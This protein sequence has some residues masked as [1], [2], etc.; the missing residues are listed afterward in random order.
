MTRICILMMVL[1]LAGCA[2]TFKYDNVSYPSR[3]LALAAARTDTDRKVAGVQVADEKVGG[4][5][6]VVIPTNDIIQQHGVVTTGNPSQE[7]KGYVAD[8]LE[9]GFL[10]M[11]DVVKRGQVFDHVDVGRSPDPEGETAGGY[12]YKLWLLGKSQSEWQWYLSKSGDS[13]RAPITQDKG[14]A[15]SARLASFNNSLLKSVALMGKEAGKPS[16]VD[17]ESSHPPGGGTRGN[18]SGL[19]TAFFINSAGFAVSNAHVVDRC[20]S[21]KAVLPEAGTASTVIVA[22]D[23]EN[24]LALLRINAKPGAFAQLRLGPT[25]RQ[26]EQIIIY[27][28]PLA[29]ALA[30]KG[31]LSIGVVSALAGLLDDSR[32]LQIS[33]PVQPGNSGGP[34]L[35]Q[36]GNV[37]GVVDS[38]LNALA[39]AKL[40]GD[41]P[42]NV[43]FAIKAGVL[44]GFLEANGVAFG[45]D[46]A[47]RQ[48]NAADI[49]DKAKAFTFMVQC[50]GHGY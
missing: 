26:G 22:T 39:A 5:I 9:I 43:N 15:G 47:K 12:D 8:V 6:L 45:T 36:Q 32:K 35:D 3:E 18:S 30:S 7:S 13:Y 23:Q 33:A 21:V 41:I 19:G 50:Y 44:A 34:V 40:T 1:V 37:I 20:N 28:Y 49:G 10:G 27:G 4:S 17:K 46:T 48:L 14:L 16:R 2:R 31:N 11:A 24:D 25:V 38:K 42:Q 29:G